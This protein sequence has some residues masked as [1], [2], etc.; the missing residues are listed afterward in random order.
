ME[1]PKLLGIAAAPLMSLF[2]F[3]G[4]ALGIKWLIATKMPDCWLKR[5]L[6]AERFQSKY[7]ASNLRILQ[8]ASEFAIKPRRVP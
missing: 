7:S 5:Q 3:G 8:K 1:L 4:V 6:L 2:L